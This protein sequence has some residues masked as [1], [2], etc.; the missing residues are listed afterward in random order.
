MA[1]VDEMELVEL[2]TKENRVLKMNLNLHKGISEN[3]IGFLR[4]RL[5]VFTWKSEDIHRIDPMVSTHK[6]NVNPFKKQVQQ[7]NKKFLRENNEVI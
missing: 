6:L 2:K 7:K 1:R 3:L 5:H 4:K